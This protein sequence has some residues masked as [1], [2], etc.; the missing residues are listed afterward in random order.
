MMA[1]ARNG[2]PDHEGIPHWPACREGKESVLVLDEN[3]RVL[4]NYDHKLIHGLEKYA[5]EITRR[6]AE[7]SGQIQ[8]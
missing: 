7:S 8:H 3:T 2:N 6:M 1:F 5:G 4:E